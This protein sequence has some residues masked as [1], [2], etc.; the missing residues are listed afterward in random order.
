MTAT[1]MRSFEPRTRAWAGVARPRAPRA[2]PA[3]TADFTKSRRPSLRLPTVG[4]PLEQLT[5]LRSSAPVA[6]RKR[7]HCLDC[8][9]SARAAER[10]L[11][12]LAPDSLRRQALDD[13]SRAA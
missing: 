10:F 2:T 12:R 7:E 6:Q 3:P 8:E 5:T 4:L 13:E 9:R 1:L 11:C